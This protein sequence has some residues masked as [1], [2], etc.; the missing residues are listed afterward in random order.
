MSVVIP[1]SLLPGQRHFG[2]GPSQIRRAHIEALGHST[3]LG[4]S[5][6]KPPVKDL[7]A[8]IKNDLRRLLQI[9]ESYEIALGNGGATAFWAVAT[10]SLV[11]RRAAHG[12]FGEFGS[13]FAKETS[14]A[15]HLADSYIYSEAPG[16]CALPVP[17]EGADIYAWPHHET[18]T[19]VRAPLRR[20]PG[21]GSEALTVIDATSIAGA[22]A[23]DWQ[24]VDVYYF[25]PQKVFAADGGLWVAVLSPRAVARVEELAGAE[26]RWMPDFLNLSV[27]LN[28][29][30]KDQTLNT[31]ALATLELFAAQLR[32]LLSLGGIDAVEARCRENSAHL[33]DWALSRDFATPFVTEQDL[34]SPVVVTIDFEGVQA[35]ALSTVLRENGVVDVDPYRS[36]GRNQLRIATFPTISNEDVRALTD[37][38]DYLVDKGVGV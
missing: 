10:T 2:S 33:Y 29:S 14:R 15:P 12:V 18:S 11:S 26:D 38:L 20:D 4:T 23:V 28:N 31:P 17:S 13:K 21:F 37:C 1:E 35:S 19:G 3:I 8:S 9:P 34:R 32:W 16:G 6:R 22:V 27:A 30:R 36:L 7:V 5:H 25:S 24:A